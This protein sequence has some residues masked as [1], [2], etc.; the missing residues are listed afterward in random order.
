MAKESMKA[1]EVKRLKLV[2]RYAAK[3]AER[4]RGLRRSGQA[5]AQFEPDPP[6]Q[7]LQTDRPPERIHANVR[8]QPYPV[9][10]N[11]FPGADSRREES[12]LVDILRLRVKN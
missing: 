1:R 7:P 12:E 5:A 4:S 9:P 3:R 2:E 6:A 10:R 11:G 8:H